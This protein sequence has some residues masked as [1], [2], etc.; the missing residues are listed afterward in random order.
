MIQIKI[1]DES[2]IG[3]ARRAAV[4]LASRLNFS[5]EDTGKIAIIATE[6]ATNVV[7]YANKPGELLLNPMTDNARQGIELIA[8]DKGPG[9][10]SIDQCLQDGYSSSG[11]SGTGLGAIK[12]L[13]QAFNIYSKPGQ[14]TLVMGQFWP[15]KLPPSAYAIKVGGICV[16]KP[17]ERIP[18][19]NWA[20]QQLADRTLILV[21]DG[22]GHG[23]DAAA[24]SQLACEVFNSNGH[25]PL[26]Q[27]IA[28]I[29]VALRKTRGAAVA[30][31]AI[32]YKKRLVHFAGLGNISALILSAAKNCHLLSHDGTAGLG[33]YRIQ[34]HIY[35]WPNDGSL[36][37]HSDGLTTRWDT[38]PYPGLMTRHP[39]LIAS[40]LYRDYTRGYD[41]VTVVVAYEQAKD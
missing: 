6:L 23:P 39:S 31:A 33:H 37:M 19:D 8:L 15:D 20:C 2:C 16:A 21:A 11:T 34:E 17:G 10:P 26:V 27:I 4:A 29:D 18:G 32:D 9:I 24:A 25:L 36:V 35:P 1:S 3:A 30:I 12:R 5:E 22:L 7:K 38:N 28:A 40:V 14:G 41:D 13:T